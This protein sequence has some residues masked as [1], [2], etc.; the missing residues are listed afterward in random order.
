MAKDYV[1]KTRKREKAKKKGG[2]SKLL[3]VILS[4][5]LVVGLLLI[6]F[7]W[8]QLKHQAKSHLVAALK[9]DDKKM[10]S[11]KPDATAL[12]EKKAT[13]EF[14]TLL[15]DKSHDKPQPSLPMERKKQLKAT[16]NASASSSS[17]HHSSYI[18]QVASMRHRKDA[19][20]LKAQLALLNFDVFIETFRNA[21][22]TWYRVRIG[23]FTTL[24]Q[25]NHARKSLEQNHFDGILSR[26]A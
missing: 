21:G 19:E 25:A 24:S 16:P 22:I 20:S 2:A 3:F 5:V 6:D 17:D 26:I 9:F 10:P 8:A 13:F 15:P 23:P 18:I 12:A 14:Y 4:L 7:D 11:V 1:A